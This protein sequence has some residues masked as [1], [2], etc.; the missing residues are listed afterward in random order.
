MEQF[1]HIVLEVDRSPGRSDV[2]LRAS[3]PGCQWSGSRLCGAPC[4]TDADRWQ[5]VAAKPGRRR[6]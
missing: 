4:E 2:L 1:S 6:D 3:D 5:F